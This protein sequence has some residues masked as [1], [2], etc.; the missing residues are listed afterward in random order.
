MCD[1][2]QT[3]GEAKYGIQN[4]EC[5]LNGEIE[6]RRAKKLFPGDVVSFR[7]TA[8]DVT[9]EVNQRGYVYKKKNKSKK[10]L[11]SG[12]RFRSDEWRAERKQKKVDRRAQNDEDMNRDPSIWQKNLKK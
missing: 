2:V 9:D 11:E 4:E 7:G 8:L 3:G 10:T 6:T 12:G 5:Y 1:L